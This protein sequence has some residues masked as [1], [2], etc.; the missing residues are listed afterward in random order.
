MK[1]ERWDSTKD[2]KRIICD[3]LFILLN[4]VLVVAGRLLS[5]SMQTLSCGIH[6]GSS[7]LT[8]DQTQAPYTGGMES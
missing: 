6:V 2:I 3:I 4:R 7:S 5:C 8:R 1:N